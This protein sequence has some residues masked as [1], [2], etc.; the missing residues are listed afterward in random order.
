MKNKYF[1]S[2]IICL[3]NKVILITGGTGTLD[4]PSFKTPEIL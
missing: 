4:R 2:N 3:K 1:K